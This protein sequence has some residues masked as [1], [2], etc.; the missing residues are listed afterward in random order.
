MALTVFLDVRIGDCGPRRL[1][2]SLLNEEAPRT[3]ENFRQLCVGVDGGRLGFKGSCFHRLVPGFMVQGGDFTNGDGTGG[4]SIFGSKFDDEPYINVGKHDRR[5]VVSMAN[6]GRNTNGSQF[7]IVFGKAAHLDGKH[8]V[9]GHVTKGID[10][11]DDLERLKTD[12]EDRPL[13]EVRIVDCGEVSRTTGE[14]VGKAMEKLSKKADKDARFLEKASEGMS[15][16]VPTM[17]NPMATY[18]EGEARRKAQERLDAQ[19]AERNAAMFLSENLS[20]RKRKLLELRQKKAQARNENQR[21]VMEEHKR[22]SAKDS[23]QKKSEREW[24]EEKE[25]KTKAELERIGAGKGK[26]FMLETAEKAGFKR[27]RE[28]QKLE[29]IEA[30]KDSHHL[31]DETALRQYEK[32]LKKLQ[33]TPVESNRGLNETLSSYGRDSIVSEEAKER[34]AKAVS[35]QSKIRVEKA[36]LDEEDVTAVNVRNEEHNRRLE[37]AFNKYTV[38]LRRNLERGTAL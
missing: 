8:V 26:L 29:N 24:R 34:V 17:D 5:G 12:N 6:A 1:E 20:S 25:K 14:K 16:P 28:R 32:R 15:F 23:E 38:E 36:R 7:F 27:D 4:E 11:L 31:S 21:M 9:F 30:A 35:Q 3:A 2:I 22:L 19:D 18:E 33:G 10:V 37:K 13:T